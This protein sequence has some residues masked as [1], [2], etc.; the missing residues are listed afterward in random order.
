MDAGGARRRRRWIAF[1]LVLIG[2][3]FL[4]FC[5]FAVIYVL[6]MSTFD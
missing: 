1:W 5:G 4:A 3:P 6:V 2:V